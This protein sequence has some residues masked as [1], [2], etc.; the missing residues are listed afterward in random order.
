MKKQIW[1]T[2][3]L[4]L[5]MILTGCSGDASGETAEDPSSTEDTEDVIEG[6][7]YETDDFS[8]AIPEGWEVLE[9]DGGVQFYKE[10]GEV[11][12]IVFSGYNLYEAYAMEQVQTLADKY[13]GTLP[14]E[15]VLFGRTFWM[16]S[17]TSSSTLQDVYI[18]IKDGVM[19]SVKYGGPDY[20][21]DPTFQEILDS[22]ELK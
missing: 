8:V 13:D 11:F 20:E 22:V 16:T 1:I 17:L 12:E 21:N 15:A 6:D 18:C 10:T 3:I 7:T 2:A 4:L 5:A 9:L 14:E 19:I